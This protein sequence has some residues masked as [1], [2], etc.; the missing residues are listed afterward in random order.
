[1]ADGLACTYRGSNLLNI[2]YLLRHD[3]MGSC[4]DIPN[5]NKIILLYNSFIIAFEIN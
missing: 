3:D 1:M 2:I 5:L 4:G